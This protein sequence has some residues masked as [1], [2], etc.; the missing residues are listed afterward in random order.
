MQDGSKR[1]ARLI[2]II[3]MV[4]ALFAGAGTFFYASS[5]QTQTP[6]V[7]PTAPVLVAAALTPQASA[8]SIMVTS[9]RTSWEE[10]LVLLQGGEEALR[11]PSRTVGPTGRIGH[12]RMLLY[13]SRRPVDAA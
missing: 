11:A 10:D 3:G 4:L 9:W 1:R 5:A 8:A 7:I 2:L 13:W 6:T 12:P